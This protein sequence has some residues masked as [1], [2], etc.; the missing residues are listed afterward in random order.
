MPG[1]G[2]TSMA[3]VLAD[4]PS[5]NELGENLNS[6][7]GADYEK[8]RSRHTEEYAALVKKLTGN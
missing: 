5:F 8:V 7:S 6:M 3:V 4:V 1:V 2:F